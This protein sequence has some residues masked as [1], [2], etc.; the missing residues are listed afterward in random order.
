MYKINYLKEVISPAKKFY[1]RLLRNCRL[2]LIYNPL[3][4]QPLQNDIN[5]YTEKINELRK[6]KYEI[7]LGALGFVPEIK[8]DDN[9][10]YCC[11]CMDICLDNLHKTI[12]NHPI[13]TQCLEKSFSTQTFEQD[14]D[15][16]FLCPYCRK[17]LIRVIYTP[18]QIHFN[19]KII[20]SD[21]PIIKIESE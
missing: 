16:R 19:G 5:E 21:N 15:L 10:T 2:S 9:N 14:N 18:F 7:L 4:E 13:C 8:E 6:I 1:K 20:Y 17:E 12:C 3:M 11:I